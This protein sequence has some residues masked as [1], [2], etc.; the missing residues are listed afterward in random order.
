MHAR[1]TRRMLPRQ[2]PPVLHARPTHSRF[3]DRSS[4]RVA[5][6]GTR[7]LMVSLLCN[8]MWLV[9]G[10]QLRLQPYRTEGKRDPVP[11]DASTLFGH[12]GPFPARQSDAALPLFE[13]QHPSSAPLRQ[14]DTNTTT[15]GMHVLASQSRY[16]LQLDKSDRVAFLPDR[17]TPRRS[18][19]TIREGQ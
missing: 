1:G 4:N 18:T 6:C 3:S 15:S 8:A 7:T 5:P 17:T 2:Y 9:R 11:V 10:P 19:I 13:C 14:P 12:P 16:L